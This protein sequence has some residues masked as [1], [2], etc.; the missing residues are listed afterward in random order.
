MTMFHLFTV[1]LL[2]YRRGHQGAATD[3]LLYK[4]I[5]RNGRRA[6]WYASALCRAVKAQQFFISLPMFLFLPFL[7]YC[8]V[9][10]PSIGDIFN[11]LEVDKKPAL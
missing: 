4:L 9:C 11:Y 10:S 2:F 7:T 1:N 8:F 5:K 6:D 3:S